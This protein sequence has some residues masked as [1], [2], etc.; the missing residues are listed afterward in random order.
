MKHKN[1]LLGEGVTSPPELSKRVF[2]P[3]CGKAVDMLWLAAC[4]HRVYG[5]DLSGVAAKQFFD[6]SGLPRTSTTADRA[7]GGVTETWSAGV[8]RVHTS[9]NVAIVE[10]DLFSIR[11]NP[12][13]RPD[14]ENKGWF[15]GVTVGSEGEKK[16]A[17]ASGPYAGDKPASV[18]ELD[19]RVGAQ[20][21]ISFREEAVRFASGGGPAMDAVWDR[22]ALVAV[23]PELRERY[24]DSHSQAPG[25]GRTHAG[26]WGIVRPTCGVR[27]P[28]A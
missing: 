23:E 7:P 16:S 20:G 5:V 27:R 14:E 19:A 2:V 6:E 1:S 18:E 24:A 13:P 26:G 17:S 15:G 28:A 9:G 4:G 10:G 25:S 3:L 8:R 22:G 12:D 11:P 21:S